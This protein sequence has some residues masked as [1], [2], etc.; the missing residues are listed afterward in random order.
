M[1]V[2]KI[3][4]FITALILLVLSTQISSPYSAL[5]IQIAIYGI[6]VIFLSRW[7]AAC[8]VFITAGITFYISGASLWYVLP[9][10]AWVLA[11]AWVL[12]D[13]RGSYARRGV[14]AVPLAALPQL[15]ISLI[16]YLAGADLGVPF[17]FFLQ[18]IALLAG[19]YAGIFAA[20]YLGPRLKQR[21]VKE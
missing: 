2:F 5:I 14:L 11:F 7:V 9:S 16:L 19:G 15:L 6:T 21:F 8:Q 17:N 10:L 1:R 20:V 13:W 18:L 4:L 12:L 3:G